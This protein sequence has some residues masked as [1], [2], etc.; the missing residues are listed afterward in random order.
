MQ[1]KHSSTLNLPLLRILENRFPATEELSPAECVDLPAEVW[2]ELERLQA[3]LRALPDV[4]FSPSCET[5]EAILQ[6]ARQ[7]DVD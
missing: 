3:T 4:Q 2:D 7:G 1:M 5:V 6:Y